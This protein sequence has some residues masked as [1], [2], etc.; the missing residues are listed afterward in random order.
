MAADLNREL[1]DLLAV[2]KFHLALIEK[3]LGHKV[4]LP[5]EISNTGLSTEQA[6][7]SMRRWLRLLDLGI[8]A[9]MVRDAL[10]DSVDHATAESLF[11]YYVLKAATADSDRDKTDFLGTYLL[12]N[13][14]AGSSRAPGV[15]GVESAE[16][17]SYMFSQKQ[18]D[19]FQQEIVTLLAVT[20]PELPQEPAHLL[21]EFQYLHQEVDEFRHFDQI[22][23]SGILQ[24]VRELKHQFG[25]AFYHPRVLSV[26]AVYNVFFGKRFDDLFREAAA[27]IK[28][29]AAKAQ[30]EG[31]SISSRVDG[32]VTVKHLSE[33]EEAK[34]LKDE[35]GHAKEQFQKVSKFKKAVDTRRSG[36][37]PAGGAPAHTPKPHA[38]PAV[39]AAPK[40]AKAAGVQTLAE[41][42]TRAIPPNLAEDNKIKGVVE[43][44]RNFVRA[45]DPS[46][47]SIVPVRNNKIALTPA[48]LEAF[49]GEYTG[50]KS[51]R[52][53]YG[54][55]ISQLVA[56]HARMQNEMED[57]K[58]KRSSSY[59][60]KPHADS[61]SYL[62]M[63]AQ[64]AVD[65]SAQM[66]VLAE[67]R[68]L[69][70]KA[71][72]MQVTADKLKA[73][74]NIVAQTLAT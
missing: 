12:K 14:A 39:A 26:V 57:Y 5:G 51:F 27:Q 70:D 2:H 37:I 69:G 61:L 67:Q 48:E 42:S 45:A 49:K 7:D 28:A 13:P 23:D 46:A 4:P 16:T 24:R 52:A 58:A 6:V 34:I 53:D 29:F 19:E 56:L 21:R 10:K 66:A 54:N 25:A 9:P 15:P 47:A 20:V 71:K 11:R 64:R 32:D 41:A 74:I 17:Y 30:Q 68:G 44:I 18:A 36:R 72:A 65:Q 55:L 63:A 62:M 22:M 8:T 38:A 43:S 35:Y 59:L 60:W 31:G 40:I 33:V 3:H 50:E 73:Q 1:R